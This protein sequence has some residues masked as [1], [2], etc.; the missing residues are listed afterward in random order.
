MDIR[1]S[2]QLIKHGFISVRNFP[3]PVTRPY[4][5]RFVRADELEEVYRLHTLVVS[6][7]HHPHAFRPDSREFMAQQINR[8]G[9]TVGVFCDDTLVAYAAISFPNEDAD[10]LGRDLPLAEPE[11]AHVA[12]YDGSAVHPD[13]RGNGLQQSMTHMRHDYALHHD[14]Y[15]ILGTVSPFNPVS[16]QNFL[17]VGCR[18]RNLKEKYGG[19]LRFIIHRDLRE[20][21][22]PALP[23]HSL[24]DVP[25]RDIEQHRAHLHRGFQGFSVVNQAQE[26]A[27]RYGFFAASETEH[28]DDVRCTGT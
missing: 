25:L 24:V 15:H 2:A 16:L 6:Q 19:M 10:N 4:E 20:P 12:D 22:P 21:F 18:V 23:P 14:R 1:Q 13:V 27:L 7:I 8:R 28:R 26:P 17:R 5:M 3:E 9:R 11:L